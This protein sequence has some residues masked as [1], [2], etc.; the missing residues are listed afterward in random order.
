MAYIVRT[1]RVG[2]SQGA[3]IF[4]GLVSAF[5][6]AAACFYFWKNHA[7]ERSA[8]IFRDQVLA[9]QEEN[10]TLNSQK[11]KMQAG[12]AEAENQLKTREDLMTQKETELAAEESGLDELG[13]AAE[14]Q[15]QQNLAQVAIVKKFN[16]LIH[17][18][19]A[20]GTTPD[21]VERSGRPVLRVPNA[22]LFAAGDTALKPEG[23]ALLNQVA[24]ALNGQLDNFELRIVSYTDTAAETAAPA[25]AS[26]KTK[27]P[28]SWDLTAARSTTLARFF[29]DETQLPFLN[30]LV[31][32][33]G[34]SEPI[35][36]NGK[37]GD[38]KNRRVEITIA[39]LPIVFHSPDL[40]KTAANATTPASTTAP[41]PAAATSSGA[42]KPKP[43]P[44]DK[45]ADKPADKP[46]GH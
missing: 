3:S 36:P 2:R 42:K 9:L 29:R 37:S 46:A 19:G 24:Q 15:S 27:P 34:D 14:R 18:L 6:A 16:D 10:E 44:A 26:A 23:K 22:Q 45:S 28:T 7:N 12:I 35:V 25:D 17:K 41:D 4:W 32:G 39:P 30:V 5:F 13:H 8:T 40:D 31:E 11:E 38:A 33:R 21:V 20:N 1:T 43:K